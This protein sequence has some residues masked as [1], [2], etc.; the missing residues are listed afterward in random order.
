MI[1]IWPLVQRSVIIMIETS[2]IITGQGPDLNSSEEFHD[3]FLT[4][5]LANQ[6]LFDY[7]AE[8]ISQLCYERSW[9]AKKAGCL[10]INLLL[11]KMPLVWTMHQ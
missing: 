8:K 5:A 4:P 3:R 11:N 6:A 9:Y 1:L 7:L 2:E 10:I